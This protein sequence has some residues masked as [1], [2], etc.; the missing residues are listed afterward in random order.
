MAEYLAVRP[1][2]LSLNGSTRKRVQEQISAKGGHCEGCGGTNFD[3]GHALY[4]GFLFLNEDQD[5]YLVA[6]SCRNP[7]CP[8]PRTA[9]RLRDNEFLTGDEEAH[10]AS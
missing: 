9:I 7:Q 10:A 5:S 2:L 4:L 8:K 1:E 6:L 3:I